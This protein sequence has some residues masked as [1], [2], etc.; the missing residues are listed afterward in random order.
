[1]LIKVLMRVHCR[2]GSLE[3]SVSLSSIKSVV[4]CRIGSLEIAVNWPFM[5]GICSL[6]HRQLRKTK[7]STER[8]RTS[9]LPHRQLR[10]TMETQVNLKRM[11][12]AA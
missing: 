3:T 8:I 10:N 5:F 7:R 9:S 6:P 1:M 4:H 11:F 12:T 2:I